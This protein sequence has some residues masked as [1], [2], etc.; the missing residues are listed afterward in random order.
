MPITSKIYKYERPDSLDDRNYEDF[1]YLLVWFQR[2]G[3][4]G[5]FMFTDR[6]VN[7]S[8]SVDILN[9]QDKDKI[10]SFINAED[11]AVGLFAENLTF[12]DFIAITSILVATKTIRVNSD[13]DIADG[14]D[15]FERV[16]VDRSSFS[17]RKTDLRYTLNFNIVLREKPLAK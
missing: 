6:N 14:S 8:T 11:R 4:Y 16:T 17:Y 7:I 3:S 15:I 2:D 12:N 9:R 5:Q 13:L 1:E 10:N